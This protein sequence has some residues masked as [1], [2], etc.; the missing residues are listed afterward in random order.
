MMLED[1]E[2]KKIEDDEDAAEPLPY[3]LP[4]IKLGPCPVIGRPCSVPD[5]FARMYKTA[6]QPPQPPSYSDAG[7]ICCSKEY[8]R[9]KPP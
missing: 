9:I 7:K 4:P 2:N 3:G 6:A 5:G 1:E 8:E